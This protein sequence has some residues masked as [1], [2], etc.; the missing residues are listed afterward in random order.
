MAGKWLGSHPL[1]PNVESFVLAIIEEFDNISQ[2]VTFN[3]IYE[4]VEDYQ[5]PDSS[6]KPSQ[7]SRD[8][9]K[10]ILDSLVIEGRIRGGLARYYLDY[11]HEDYHEGP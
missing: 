8:E 5:P 3:R 11:D 4:I 2:G 7:P 9:I 1:Y 10:S 6:G